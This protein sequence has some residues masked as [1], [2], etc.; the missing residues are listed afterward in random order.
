[1]AWFSK[2]LRLLP[3]VI[4]G[5]LGLIIGLIIGLKS[6]GLPLMPG[7]TIEMCYVGV[8]Q[9][10]DAHLVSAREVA[11]DVATS[12]M[13]PALVST[14]TTPS[15]WNVVWLGDSDLVLIASAQEQTD[16]LARIEAAKGDLAQAV[17][18]H[19]TNLESYAL[20]DVVPSNELEHRA[21]GVLM[22]RLASTILVGTGIGVLG[23]LAV[24]HI[25][26]MC[27]GEDKRL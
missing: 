23:G 6:L 27:A 19:N 16:A 20:C 21:T 1:M 14:G 8:E 4:G 24:W 10:S 13:I 25:R 18:D 5:L 9:K 15:I 11:R 7:S 12:A 22:D 3:A 2:Y 17:E 26:R